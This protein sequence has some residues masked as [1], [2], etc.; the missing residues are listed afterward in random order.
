MCSEL[1]RIPITYNGVPIFGF[2]V[3]LLIWL[4][5]GG[6]ATWSTAKNNANDWTAALKAHLPTILIVAAIIAL[7]I[8]RMMPDG[9]PLRSY[10]LLVLSGIVL[11]VILAIHRAV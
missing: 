6:L 9:V 8:P 7:G 4:A 10:G 11:G 2:G 3:V 5:A 1:L